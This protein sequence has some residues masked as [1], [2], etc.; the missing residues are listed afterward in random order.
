MEGCWIRPRFAGY[1][2][3]QAKAGDIIEQHLRGTVAEADLLDRLQR[4][5]E[6][7]AR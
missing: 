6:Q 5:F 2:G 1:L 3:F 7:S 4:L